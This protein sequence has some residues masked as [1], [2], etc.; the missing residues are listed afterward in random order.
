MVDVDTDEL[1]ESPGASQSPEVVD[2][3]RRVARQTN[4]GSVHIDD[5]D[6]RTVNLRASH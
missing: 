6:I 5:K 4:D 1:A 2:E 3:T